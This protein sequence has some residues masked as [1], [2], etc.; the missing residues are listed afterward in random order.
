MVNSSCFPQAT[1]IWYTA[2]RYTMMAPCR[3]PSA[4]QT[5]TR[6]TLRLHNPSLGTGTEVHVLI[7]SDHI[8][9]SGGL[10]FAM[11]VILLN[12]VPK[13]GDVQSRP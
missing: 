3:K 11:L 8:G 10:S 13:M 5:A 6:W 7:L 9:L 12:Y 2:E 1:Y 4:T